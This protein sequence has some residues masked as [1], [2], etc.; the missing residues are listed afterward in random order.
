MRNDL[1]IV[2]TNET[3][4]GLEAAS[5]ASHI[6][7]CASPGTDA[8][9]SVN[10]VGAGF[11]IGSVSGTF[12]HTFDLTTDLAGIS[13]SDFLNGL[14]SR[15]AYVDIHDANFPGGEIRGQLIEQVS[16]AP[17]PETRAL[18]G[19]GLSGLWMRRRRRNS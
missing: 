10:F 19:V 14:F 4:V 15:Q 16:Q 7:C 3:F 17:E 11:P 9:V 13:L 5:V 18:L 1:H 6:H 12:V 8:P 2:I